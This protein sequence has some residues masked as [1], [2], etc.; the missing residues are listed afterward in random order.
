MPFVPPGNLNN[1]L[2]GEYDS[3]TGDTFVYMRGMRNLRQWS[4]SDSE[5]SPSLERKNFQHC[6]EEVNGLPHRWRGNRSV[7]KY[8]DDTNC[9]EK[10]CIKNAASTFSV[11]KQLVEIHAEGSENLFNLISERSAAIGMKV[12]PNKTQ[13]F[14]FW[15][16]LAP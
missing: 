10:L 12:Y 14:F 6:H 15:C 11:H 2:T 5:R 3:V 13:L 16:S 7:L 1:S 8:I 4:D 9:N